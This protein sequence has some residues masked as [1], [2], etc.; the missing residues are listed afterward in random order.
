MCRVPR[1]D[2][3]RTFCDAPHPPHG[4]QVFGAKS[5]PFTAQHNAFWMAWLPPWWLV[6][7][8]AGLIFVDAA[9]VTLPCYSLAVQM[10]SDFKHHMLP[11]GVKVGFCE[12]SHRVPCSA[13]APG[14]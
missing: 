6:L 3:A 9:M 5:C 12:G 1:H 7:I 8:I 2:F 10:G 11:S 14:R 13:R 4:L